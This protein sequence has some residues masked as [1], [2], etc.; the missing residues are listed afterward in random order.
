MEFRLEDFEWNSD[1][2]LPPDCPIQLFPN[3]AFTFSNTEEPF[4]QTREVY[5]WT[6]GQLRFRKAKG[7]G[8][9]IY[10]VKL[11]GQLQIAIQYKNANWRIGNLKEEH[12]QPPITQDAH[13][14]IQPHLGPLSKSSGGGAVIFLAVVTLA[15]LCW[16]LSHP[17]PGAGRRADRVPPSEASAA[18]LKEAKTLFWQKD[19]DRAQQA[20]EAALKA[21]PKNA[22]ANYILACCLLTEDQS[23]KALAHFTTALESKPNDPQIRL[24]RGTSY[25]KLNQPMKAKGDFQSVTENSKSNEEQRARAQ[26]LLDQIDGAVAEGTQ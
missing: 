24:M 6:A 21:D 14:P 11:N 19:F 9:P 22:D 23:Q 17:N 12:R 8:E 2:R 20:S 7:A 18:K 26:S 4:D 16:L 3:G 25:V 5:D 10:V 13:V 1:A 15:G